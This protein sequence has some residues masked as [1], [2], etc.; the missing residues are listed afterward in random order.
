MM[1]EAACLQCNQCEK[2]KNSCQGQTGTFKPEMCPDI[3]CL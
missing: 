2:F 3:P 1:C